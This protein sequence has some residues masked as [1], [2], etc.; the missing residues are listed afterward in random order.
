MKPRRFIGVDWG[1]TKGQMAWCQVLVNPDG[2]FKVEATGT[3]PEI[4]GAQTG[5]VEVPYVTGSERP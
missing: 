4:P 2:S 3:F 1:D 5:I